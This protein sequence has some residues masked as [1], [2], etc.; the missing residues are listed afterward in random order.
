[1]RTGKQGQ[2]A[3]FRERVLPPKEI[4]LPEPSVLGRRIISCGLSRSIL[5]SA[6]LM[7]SGESSPENLWFAMSAFLLMAFIFGTYVPQRRNLN[8]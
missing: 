2:A 7:S 8:E 3:V 4:R 6:I 1:M 5:W